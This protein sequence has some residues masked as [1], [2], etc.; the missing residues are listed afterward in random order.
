MLIGHAL[1]LVG[2][3]EGVVGIRFDDL[4]GDDTELRVFDDGTSNGG[5]T[6]DAKERLGVKVRAIRAGQVSDVG[7]LMLRLITEAVPN[8]IGEGGVEVVRD[9]CHLGAIQGL[10]YSTRPDEE[11]FE[12][13]RNRESTNAR[14]HTNSLS[15]ALVKRARKDAWARVYMSSKVSKVVDDLNRVV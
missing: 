14:D 2:S 10:G 8:G 3:R 5:G 15:Y 12:L 13:M 4:A 1:G 7:V 9:A 11:G 6:P